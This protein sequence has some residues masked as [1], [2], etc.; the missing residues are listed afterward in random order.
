MKLVQEHLKEQNVSIGTLHSADLV[1]KLMQKNDEGALLDPTGHTTILYLHRN[2]PAFKV[3][4]N[5][6]VK[7]IL[8]RYFSRLYDVT[9]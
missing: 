1:M 7:E 3:I 2:R 5:N 9:F 4:S 6:D 8:E